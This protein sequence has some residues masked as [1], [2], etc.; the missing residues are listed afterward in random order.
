MFLIGLVYPI[1]FQ[2]RGLKKK[3]YYVY[4]LCNFTM[5]DRIQ[6]EIRINTIYFCMIII[7]ILL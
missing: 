2:H 7:T 3:F 4:Y 1:L 5:N 6:I